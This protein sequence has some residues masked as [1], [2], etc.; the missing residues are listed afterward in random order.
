ELEVRVKTD[1]TGEK[2][3]AVS[4]RVAVGKGK[5]HQLAVQIVSKRDE[6][7]AAEI[8]VEQTVRALGEAC[9]GKAAGS[10]KGDAGR[11][12][13]GIDVAGSQI[14]VARRQ[15]QS[16]GNGIVQNRK[17]VAKGR[18]QDAVIAGEDVLA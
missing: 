9:P 18:G 6:R 12:G 7:T 2:A 8:E 17:V 16:I 14:Q 15:E 4:G 1:A 3:D 5:T 10:G 11:G 13:V